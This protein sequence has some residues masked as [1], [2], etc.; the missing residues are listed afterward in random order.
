MAHLQAHFAIQP[1]HALVIDRPAL[2]SQQGMYPQVAVARPGFGDLPNSL[3]QGNLA[4][5]A[6]LVVPA[7]TMD[8][9]HSTGSTIA[10]AIAI[11]QPARQ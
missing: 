2:S 3:L 1:I 5:L 6:A 7:G 11:N 8:L 4:I 9:N 10:D